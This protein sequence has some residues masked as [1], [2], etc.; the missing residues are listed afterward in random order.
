MTTTSMVMTG[1]YGM[2]QTA[3]VGSYITKSYATIEGVSVLSDVKLH[4]VVLH[5]ISSNGIHM[6]N[7]RYLGVET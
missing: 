6:K 3:S 4:D 5:Y 2:G 1:S 7:L